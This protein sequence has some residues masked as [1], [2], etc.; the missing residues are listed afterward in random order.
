MFW[1]LK[2]HLQ[3][4]VR[5]STRSLITEFVCF[6]FF[7]SLS[8]FVAQIKFVFY[9]TLTHFRKHSANKRNPNPVGFILLQHECPLKTV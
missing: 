9:N 3:L 4:N 5:C 1:L 2:C 6:L 7:L 8:Q